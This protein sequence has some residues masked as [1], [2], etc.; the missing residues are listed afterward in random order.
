LAI[1]NEAMRL[2]QIIFLLVVCFG[3]TGCNAHSKRIENFQS[4]VKGTV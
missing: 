1:T 2:V 3:V 4:E